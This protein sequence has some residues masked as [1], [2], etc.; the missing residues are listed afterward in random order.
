MYYGT[1]TY[2]IRRTGSANYK[3]RRFWNTVPSDLSSRLITLPLDD[4][5]QRVEDDD[6]DDDNDDDDD[7]DDDGN[8]TSVCDVVL[9]I[10]I[11]VPYNVSSGPPPH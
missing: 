7:D 10:P 6:D 11:T 8:C 5:S 9:G 1:L 2:A 4:V 3:Y